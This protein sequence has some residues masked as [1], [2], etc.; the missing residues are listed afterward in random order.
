MKRGH[1]YA[2]VRELIKL[3]LKG[4]VT[5]MRLGKGTKL[6]LPYQSVIELSWADEV[7]NDEDN[8]D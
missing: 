6:D 8:A 7:S 4:R 3:Q 5:K 1:V 2:S